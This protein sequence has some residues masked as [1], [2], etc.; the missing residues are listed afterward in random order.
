MNI[1]E[2]HLEYPVRFARLKKAFYASLAAIVLGEIV[3]IHVL[4]R[5]HGHFGFEDLPAFGSLCGL[6]SCILIV[7]VSKFLGHLWLMRKEDYYD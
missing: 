5:G 3:V 6:V 1:F 4:R 2:K 7:V